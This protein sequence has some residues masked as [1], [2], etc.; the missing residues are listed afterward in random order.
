MKFPL[1]GEFEN[2]VFYKGSHLFAL[3]KKL[4][5]RDRV[6]HFGAKFRACIIS[7]NAL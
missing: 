1:Q 6:S 7:I 4:S 3:N 5:C 2:T